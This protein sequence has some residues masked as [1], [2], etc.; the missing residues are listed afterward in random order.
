MIRMRREFL[1]TFRSAVLRWRN[2]A[3]LVREFAERFEEK[4]R[5]KNMIDF[6]DMEQYALEDSY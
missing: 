4:K 5:S 6:S 1:K 3:S 2:W